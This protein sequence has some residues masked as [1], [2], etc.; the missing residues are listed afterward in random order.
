MWPI[1]Y[2]FHEGVG[3]NEHERC[4]A[5]N[6]SEYVELQEDDQA[7]RQQQ[8]KKYC[9]SPDG[10][11]AGGD[12]AASCTLDASIEIAIDNIVEDATGAAHH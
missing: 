6:D 8:D 5:E 1:G 12:G 2:A 7:K 9:S 3:K 4:G 11:H 10:Y